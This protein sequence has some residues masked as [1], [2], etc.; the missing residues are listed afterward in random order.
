MA[1]IFSKYKT[2][3]LYICTK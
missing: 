1:E 2:N 3:L